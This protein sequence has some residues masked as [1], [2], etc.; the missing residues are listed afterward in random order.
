MTSQAAS[1]IC[2]SFNQWQISRPV[3]SGITVCTVGGSPIVP[4]GYVITSRSRRSSCT[5]SGANSYH[6]KVP[7]GSS[8][9][10]CQGS[11]IPAGWAVRSTGTSTACVA[12]GSGNSATI[13]PLSGDGPF[14]VCANT[15]LPAGFV[16]THIISSWSCSSDTWVVQKPNPTRGVTT[17]HCGLHSQIPTGF[18]ITAQRQ[19]SQCRS[20]VGSS[21]LGFDITQP[22]TTGETTVCPISVIP[23]GFVITGTVSAGNSSCGNSAAYKIA[24]LS[25]PG[26]FEVCNISGLPQGYVV[27]SVLSGDRCGAH[28]GHV[29]QQPASTGETRICRYGRQDFSVTDAPIASGYAVVGVIQT[30]S[31]PLSNGLFISLPNPDSATVMCNGF[32]VPDGYIRSGLSI[33]PPRCGAIGGYTILPLNSSQAVVP[34]PFID[35]E[36]DV[37]TAP[38]APVIECVVQGVNGGLI[39]QATTNPSGC[40]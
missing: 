35:A 5:G 36:S 12:T 22:I 1:S 3:T 24:V 7:S 21:G 23:E 27:T 18:V 8:Q 15:T 26:P 2:G 11:A 17:V 28:G 33:N 9:F 31:C 14:Y 37:T 6:V 30:S 25:G 38:N 40:H 29:V 32:D 13:V 16:I 10:I 4:A 39:S 19:L 20:A 34:T